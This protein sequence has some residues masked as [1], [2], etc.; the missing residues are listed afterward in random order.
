[1]LENWLEKSETI[2]KW[3]TS[4]SS[5]VPLVCGVRQGAI[6]S[7]ILFAIYVDTVLDNLE[8]SNL[9][10]YISSTCYNSFMYADDIILMSISVY[11]LQCMLNICSTLFEE[12]DL[13]INIAKSHCLR[14]GCRYN[15]PC[16]Q[17]SLNGITIEWVQ[18]TKFL[19]ITV[20]NAA[21][22]TCK[23]N[24]AKGKFYSSANTILGSLGPSA[25]LSV[26]LF[27]ILTV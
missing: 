23:W 9:G 11:E 17:L 8:K 20:C 15:I 22:F 27:F 4:Y 13:P 2:V 3:Q 21:K 18:E 5:V 10:C 12:L 7:P 14:V 1:M 26:V 24:E 25:P 16:H 6:L 19:G